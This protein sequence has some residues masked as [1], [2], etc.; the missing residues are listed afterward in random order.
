MKS[1]LAWLAAQW[2]KNS[3]LR[4]AVGA[5][6]AVELAPYVAQVYQWT[7]G[8]SVFPDWHLALQNLGKAIVGAVCLFLLRLW[9]KPQ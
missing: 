7:I 8:S 1:I 9:Q 3:P 5:F 4:H 6:L 2:A